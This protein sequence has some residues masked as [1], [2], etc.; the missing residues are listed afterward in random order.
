M[1]QKFNPFT[2][3]PDLVNPP[4][5]PST[6]D[7]GALAGLSDDDHPQYHNDA[8]G[9]ARYLPI[10]DLIEDTRVNIMSTTPANG[11][12]AYTTDTHQEF[13]YYN[14]WYAHGIELS[15]VTGSGVDLGSEQQTSPVNITK[16][17]IHGKRASNFAIGSNTDV[18]KASSTLAPVRTYAGAIWAYL[19]GAWAQIVTNFTF[20]ENTTYGSTLEYLPL[21]KT[22]YIEV[23]TGDSLGYLGLNGRPIVHAWSVDLGPYPSQDFVG[24]GI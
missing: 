15:L 9:D 23:S 19:S 20:R 2:R 14:G 18:S 4:T 12:R 10:T 11:T 5:D 8:R 22:T 1:P 17:T 7:H 16:E 6:I 21:G 13:V 24:G 3:K